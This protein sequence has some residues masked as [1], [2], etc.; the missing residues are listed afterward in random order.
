M[1]IE[2]LAGSGHC[3]ISNLRPSESWAIRVFKCNHSE[4]GQLVN[5]TQYD[6]FDLPFTDAN[7]TQW[8]LVRHKVEIQPFESGGVIEPPTGPISYCNWRVTFHYGAITE[9]AVGGNVAFINETLSAATDTVPVDLSP[10]PYARL[11]PTGV[12]V[13]NT[14]IGHKTVYMPLLIYAVTIKRWGGAN[15]FLQSMLGAVNAVPFVVRKTG[16][17]YEPGYVRYFDL[18]F[19]H[20]FIYR[21]ATPVIYTVKFLISPV[22]WDAFWYPGGQASLPGWAVACKSDGTAIKFYPRADLN[23]LLI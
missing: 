8:R 12:I 22:P 5:N 4:L 18:D 21:H 13:S 10:F 3:E 7:G 20:T 15:P 11:I 6:Y 16:T 9:T 1:A 23:A 14:E 17:V 2:E 19:S